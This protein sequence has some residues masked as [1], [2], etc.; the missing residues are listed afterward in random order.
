M[1]FLSNSSIKKPVVT[2]WL[3]V[4]ASSICMLF[5]HVS[6]KYAVPTPV[7]A[8]YHD[9]PRGTI[10]HLPLSAE[11][12]LSG[13]I[14]AGSEPSTHKPLF[15]HFF[16]PEC[17]C[18]RFNMPQFRALVQKYG[19][20]VSF[21]I[22]VMG[23]EKYGAAQMQAKFDLPYPIPVLSDSAIAAACGVYSTPQAVLIGAD[24]RL[25]YRGNYNCSRYCSDEKTGFAR[26]A[27][28][29]LFDHH[30]SLTLSPLAF[31]AYGC[32]LPTCRQ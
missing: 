20:Q 2:G 31:R 29:S 25:F 4:L 15:L 19:Q 30:Y 28:D 1:T 23:P 26:Q 6:W 5:W 27:L 8:S 32:Q 13:N 11:T 24:G 9:V 14:P 12:A 21:A 17:P 3:A 16:N 18:S 7:P 22:V 10:V